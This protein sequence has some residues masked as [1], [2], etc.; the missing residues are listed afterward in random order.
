MPQF[1]NRHTIGSFD[2]KLITNAIETNSLTKR[3]GTH[4]AVSGLDLVV[5]TGEIFGFLGPNGAGKTTTIRMLLGLARPT[6][7]SV[8]LMG[9]PMPKAASELRFRIG[10][11]LEPPAFY[12]SLSAITNLRLLALTSGKKPTHRINAL[13]DSVGLSGSKAKRVSGFSHGMRQRLGIAAAL[14]HD[15][16]L[17]VLDEPLTGL[18]PD[19]IRDV[20][21]LMKNL[22]TS[23][24]TVFLSS[25]ALS[26]V[27]QTCT[28][29]AFLSKGRLAGQ[30]QVDQFLE[31]SRTVRVVIEPKE[32]AADLLK[33]LGW[34]VSFHAGE[35]I[36][37]SGNRDQVRDALVQNGLSPIQVTQRG[38]SLED[39]YIEL[40]GSG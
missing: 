30:Y 2:S 15:P 29:V 24:K 26:E 16:E 27:Q 10:A 17:I 31:E 38:R 28:S 13:I 1:V 4:A 32:Q 18:D 14:L 19:G 37:E 40:T 25:H 36:V 11:L 39:L 35:L 20:R 3:F 34:R 7:G 9:S 6:S 21:I 12:P 5:P 22:A 8:S 33:N 23:G